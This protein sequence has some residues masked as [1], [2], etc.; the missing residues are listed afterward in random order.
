[1][2]GT[3]LLRS[4][5][6]AIFKMGAIEI[7]EYNI[8]NVLTNTFFLIAFV[9]FFLRAIGWQLVLRKFE[10]S[11]AYPFTAVHYIFLLLIGYMYFNESLSLQKILAVILIIAG[12]I[13]I[14]LSKSLKN[15]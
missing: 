13:I 7:T 6:S 11:F 10:L 12:T 3:I 14:S 4:I 9:L 5:S 2:I 15:G 8:F 1:M